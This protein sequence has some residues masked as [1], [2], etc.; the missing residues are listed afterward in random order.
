MS[1][2][3]GANSNIVRYK[4]FVLES[5]QSDDALEYNHANHHN[6]DNSWSTEEQHKSLIERLH[7]QYWNS[8]QRVLVNT[9]SWQELPSAMAPYHR[10][11]RQKKVQAALVLQRWIRKYLSTTFD[12]ARAMKRVD[13]MARKKLQEKLIARRKLLVDHTTAMEASDEHEQRKNKSGGHGHMHGSIS[14]VTTQSQT[15]KHGHGVHGSNSIL[16]PSQS[17]RHKHTTS[18][19]S[20]A[21]P[22]V[23]LRQNGGVATRSNSLCVDAFGDSIAPLHSSEGHEDRRRSK[24]VKRS[25]S[26]SEIND[27]SQLVGA[28]GMLAIFN[29][30]GMTPPHP[31]HHHGQSHRYS[32]S[33]SIGVGDRPG[34]HA[35]ADMIF[36]HTEVNWDETPSL[37]E[38]FTLDELP[39]RTLE[40]SHQTQSLPQ[41]GVESPT[42]HRKDSHAT[43]MSAMSHKNRSNSIKSRMDGAHSFASYLGFPQPSNR[44]KLGSPSIIEESV[45]PHS[46]GPYDT[47]TSTGSMVGTGIA[48]KDEPV[49][50]TSMRH[51]T[52]HSTPHLHSSQKQTHLQVQAQGHAQGQGLGPGHGHTSTM[53]RPHT[54]NAAVRPSG[55]THE[56]LEE[57]EQKEAARRHEAHKARRR[58]ELHAQ[59]LKDK[60]RLCR[61]ASNAFGLPKDVFHGV[62]DDV[63]TKIGLKFLRAMSANPSIYDDVQVKKR[64]SSSYGRTTRPPKSNIW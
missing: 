39:Q 8:A 49:S 1:R 45:R 62:K 11:D 32:V 22:H 17:H 31:S 12:F 53:Q 54:A 34:P 21:T 37:Q 29:A 63:G 47:L 40:Q 24:S 38:N 19:S 33:Q 52:Y 6:Q 56:E 61:S 28:A 20:I 10:H 55:P 9:Q 18:S 42:T 25:M 15:Q 58:E 46:A 14:S 51:A 50:P 5:Q 27:I 64:A 59:A 3:Y 57:M 60:R 13:A 43:A 7:D 44:E 2:I 41:L 35:P 48:C 30:A 16:H 36:Q 23:T 4:A 26:I